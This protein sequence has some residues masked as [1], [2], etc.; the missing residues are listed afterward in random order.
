[1]SRGGKAHSITDKGINSTLQHG[2][3]HGVHDIGDQ[4]LM[5]NPARP[6]AMGTLLSDRPQHTPLE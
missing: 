5:D 3:V 6:P 4:P 1:M 2:R